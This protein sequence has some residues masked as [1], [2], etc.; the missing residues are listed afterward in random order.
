MLS[1]TSRGS[2]LLLVA[3]V[4]AALVGCS[5]EAKKARIMERAGKYFSS[6][7]LEKAKIEYL[8]VLQIDP[9][10]SRA[11]ERLGFIAFDQGS[12]L[13]AIAHLS[14][15]RTAEPNNLAAREKLIRAL[16]M[17]G[18]V[19][20]ARREALAV[21]EKSSTRG[22]AL[23]VLSETIRNKADN[24]VTAEQLERFTD[25]TTPLY[26]IAQANQLFLKGDPKAAMDALQRAKRMDANSA[27]VRSAL[28]ALYLRQNDQKNAAVEIQQA[29]EL[30][31]VR[32]PDRIRYAEYLTQTGA[33]KEGID[34]LKDLIAQ[35]PDFLTPKYHLARI[36]LAEKNYDAAEALAKD[37]LGRDGSHLDM[38]VL[39]AHLALARKQNDKAIQELTALRKSFPAIGMLAYHLARIHLVAGQT[40]AAIAV[41][42]DGVAI[43]PDYAES[44]LLL[45]ELNIRTG[46]AN[47]AIPLL[48]ALVQSR[49]TVV[50]AQVL[51]INALRAVGKLDDAVGVVREQI[52]IYPSSPLP[53]M[54]L[55]RILLEQKQPA[56]ARAALEKA[57]EIAPNF[58]PALSEL[59]DFDLREKKFEA[60][61]ARAQEQKAKNPTA[62]EPF[63]FEGKVF[64]A[65][66]QWEKA[67]VAFQKALDLNPNLSGA[68]ELLLLSLISSGRTQQA[69]TQLEQALAKNPD[70]SRALLLSGM[71]YGQTKDLT[72]ASERYEKLLS[73]KPD[74]PVALNNLAYLYSEQPGQLDRA[75]EL[76][77]KA[78][79][80]DPE[81]PMVADTLGWI[82]YK[83]ADYDGAF[84][85]LK[86]SAAKLPDEPEVQFHL[87][88]ASRMKGDT[89]TASMAL[90]AAINSPRDFPDKATARQE[91]VRLEKGEPAGAR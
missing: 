36:Y 71:L 86:E 76:A 60:A 21:L 29:A 44:V 18:R 75:F 88:M 33:M 65:Q 48:I 90:K 30:A 35:A 87:G 80:L 91:L 67:E 41:L 56:E 5:A 11:N 63:Y 25:R 7:D 2:K 45:S 57:V 72:K 20:E 50:Q 61:L 59:V 16:L 22:D 8:N 23:L 79:A 31:P 15:V 28:G 27:T 73:V 17:I 64:A 66:R 84:A 81:S 9:K 39:N 51:L 3:Y 82:L 74:V 78:R 38:H 4:M 49:P 43:D 68:Y 69:V 70:D 12:P 13:R 37:V 85:L 1:L 46:K 62:G 40:D 83:R 24:D 77:T 32:S 52:R 14:Q 26:V 10:E 6:G 42:T 89:Q 55:A 54:T 19:T 58:G 53:H 47:D 34:Y